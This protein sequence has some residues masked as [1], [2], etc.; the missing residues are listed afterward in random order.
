LAFLLENGPLRRRLKKRVNKFANGNPKVLEKFSSFF[1][2]SNPA[3]KI[4]ENEA[5]RELG[6]ALKHVENYAKSTSCGWCKRNVEP[7]SKAIRDMMELH[8]IGDKFA[9]EIERREG[10]KTIEGHVE[11]LSKMMEE[12]RNYEKEVRTNV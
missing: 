6:E 5:I 12:A 8:E 1:E 4:S 11:K 2:V 3:P 7:I 9:K 10:L